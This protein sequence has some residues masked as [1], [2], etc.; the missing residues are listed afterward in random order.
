MK[1]GFDIFFV[2]VMSV[3]GAFI[4]GYLV[5]NYLICWLFAPVRN[6]RASIIRKLDKTVTLVDSEFGTFRGRVYYNAMWE[7]A[8]GLLSSLLGKP[9]GAV[10]QKTNFLLEVDAEGKRL[11]FT[12]SMDD[13]S[14]VSEGDEGWLRH[15]GNK[16][17]SFHPTTHSDPD[18]D[19][20]SGG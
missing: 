7:I 12:V 14:S 6:A 2:V 11:E 4:V 16:F 13:Y 19:S 1:D 9:I 8:S 3:L 15:K 17:I 20:W 5:W 10:L 18:A